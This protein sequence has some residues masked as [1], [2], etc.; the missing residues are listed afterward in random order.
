MKKTPAKPDT[1]EKYFL[2]IELPYVETDP[3]NILGR[4]WRSK[5]SRFQKTKNDI[6]RLTLGKTPKTP[7]TKFKISIVRH[8]SGYLDFDNLV[9]SMK[10]VIDGFTLAKIIK[11]DDWSVIRQENISFDQVKTKRGAKKFLVIK[12]EEI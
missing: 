7:L 9:A 5:H 11:N 2:E 12:V 3:N 6:Y 4:H 8:A 10:P 1:V